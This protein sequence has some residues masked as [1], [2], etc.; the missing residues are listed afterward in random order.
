MGTEYD[1]TQK[2]A[3][4]LDMIQFDEEWQCYRDTFGHP[5]QSLKDFL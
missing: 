5:G 2:G 4:Y 1:A 3:K